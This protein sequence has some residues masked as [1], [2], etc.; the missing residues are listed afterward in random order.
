MFETTDQKGSLCNVQLIMT[1]ANSRSLAD[2]VNAYL[3]VA[4][5][6]HQYPSRLF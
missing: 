3:V 6:Q 4:K 5:T 2:L 1:Y